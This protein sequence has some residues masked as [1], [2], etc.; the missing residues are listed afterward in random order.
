[1]IS[2]NLIKYIWVSHKSVFV[3]LVLKWV[4]RIVKFE[5]EVFNSIIFFIQIADCLLHGS[6]TLVISDL[7]SS[8][9]K[10]FITITWVVHILNAQRHGQ[11]FLLSKLGRWQ[12]VIFSQKAKNADSDLRWIEFKQIFAWN[13][14]EILLTRKFSPVSLCF[15]LLAESGYLIAL[16]V[17]RMQLTCWDAFS[18][19]PGLHFELFDLVCGFAVRCLLCDA[20][21]I[22]RDDETLHFGLLLLIV[23]LLGEKTIANSSKAKFYVGY[24]FALDHDVRGRCGI[25]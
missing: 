17:L 11:V 14:H 19:G 15:A 4:I 20:W 5:L 1:M 21:R 25:F 8:L 23:V 24:F 6:S 2:L 9:L 16:R 7:A 10:I 22:F 13:D 3:L 12:L 18:D